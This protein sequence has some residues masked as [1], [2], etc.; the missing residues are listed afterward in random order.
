MQCGRGSQHADWLGPTRLVRRRHRNPVFSWPP[1]L[2]VSLEIRP[3]A[4]TFRRSKALGPEEIETLSFVADPG[5]DH[6][7][8]KEA[9]SHDRLAVV[10]HVVRAEVVLVPHEDL[11]R[12]PLS[13]LELRQVALA[14][15]DAE[16]VE[17]KVLA[18]ARAQRADQIAGGRPRSF[19]VD[20]AEIGRAS[21][22]ERV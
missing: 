16:R 13:Q 19:G 17:P 14:Q 12:D 10:L 11:T 18:Q 3:P 21:C 1:Q 4:L 8:A 9:V 15:I 20:R 6:P 2:L 7:P 5:L 22:R